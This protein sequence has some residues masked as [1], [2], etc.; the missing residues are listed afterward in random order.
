MA[1]NNNLGDLLTDIANA[2]REKKGT[3]GSINAQ[4]FASEIASISTGGS[5]V[6]GDLKIKNKLNG[7]SFG[8]PT[9]QTPIF[10]KELLHTYEFEGGSPVSLFLLPFNFT[11]GDMSDGYF[12]QDDSIIYIVEN[13]IGI[14]DS[15]SK[16]GS[17]FLY[18]KDAYSIYVSAAGRSDSPSDNPLS[19]FVIAV[20]NEGN[21]D[22][23]HFTMQA[24]KAPPCFVAGTK[25]TLYSGEKKNVEDV[26]YEDSLL[27]WNFDKGEYDS[28]K[29]LWIKKEQMS[30][31]YYLCQFENGI[32]LKLVGA[33]GKCHRLFS[34]E[35]GMFLSATD[36][37]GKY[38]YSES[39]ITRVV[40][41]ELIEEEVSYYN[42][43][44]NYHINLFANEVLTSCR[45]NNIYP[46][47]DMK[48]VKDDRMTREPRWKKYEKFRDYV[49][50]GRYLDGLRLYEQENFSIDAI[51]AYCENLENLRKEINDFEV[52]KSIAYGI[53][54]TQV[55]WIDRGGLVYGF[56]IYMS[57]Q[58]AHD[59][60]AKIICER[61]NINVE[62]PALY[63]DN[64]GWVRYSTDYIYKKSENEI[65]GPQMDAIK[66]FIKTPNKISNGTIRIG[67]KSSPYVSVSDIEVMDKYGFEYK[68]MKGISYGKG[69]I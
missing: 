20:D 27:V 69:D 45:Y 10:D 68:L 35:D 42:I 19:M 52:N 16:Y 14:E 1:K 51:V 65:T 44:T 50:L 60:L 34:V 3:S 22:T 5:A 7:Y 6:G 36:M 33:N 62:N 26:N 55:G 40:S 53:E 32:S 59:K 61:M 38:A 48:F 2:I 9:F 12:P 24:A 18:L 15:M 21:F 17:W 43:I 47:V 31:R 57:G 23:D 11:G 37:V 54:N 8:G 63:L 39:G 4:D 41:C 13:L 28:A 29:P 67:T 25:I 49:V 58:E 30:T 46:I 56:P 66:A 64:L